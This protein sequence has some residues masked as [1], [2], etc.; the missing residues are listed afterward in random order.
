MDEKG[1][2]LGFVQRSVGVLVKA[3]EKTA[4]PWQPG[5][6]ETV[7]AFGAVGA[8]EQEIPLIFHV[9]R[10]ILWAQSECN[11]T[12]LYSDWMLSLSLFM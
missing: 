9:H 12:S 2:F 3:S 8:L 4:F 5:Q 6:Q 10:G 7:T 11:I 1:F